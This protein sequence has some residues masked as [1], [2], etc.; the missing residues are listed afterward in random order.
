MRLAAR[1]R[2]IKDDYRRIRRRMSHRFPVGIIGATPRFSL[3]QSFH[4]NA[5]APRYEECHQHQ[6]DFVSHF[7]F[8]LV[9]MHMMRRLSKGSSSCSS[10]YFLEIITSPPGMAASSLAARR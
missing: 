6:A 5:I 4:D 1:A 9:K 2:P 10:N 8:T 7:I 3:H